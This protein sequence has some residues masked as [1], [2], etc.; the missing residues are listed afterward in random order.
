MVLRFAVVVPLFVL[1]FLYL[2]SFSLVSSP[3]PQTVIS[4]NSATVALA[5]GHADSYS[6]PSLLLLWILRKVG[7]PKPGAVQLHTLR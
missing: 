5:N 4:S 1:F 7:P 6:N 2:T 3:V